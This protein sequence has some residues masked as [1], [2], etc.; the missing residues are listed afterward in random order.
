MC[1]CTHT[2]TH[3][4]CSFP[5]KYYTHTQS[6]KGRAMDLVH[7]NK[8]SIFLMKMNCFPK[9][10]KNCYPVLLQIFLVPLREGSCCVFG[11]LLY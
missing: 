8:D 1:G 7:V 4:Q 10:K 6:F 11:P 5:Y 2:H 9:L 3:V